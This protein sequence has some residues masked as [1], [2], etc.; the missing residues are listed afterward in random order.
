[1]H[2]SFLDHCLEHNEIPPANAYP[3]EDPD[4]ETLH[5]F[6]M[7]ESLERAAKNRRMLLKGWDIFCTEQ[8]HG[9]YDSYREIVAANGGT[10]IL[11]KG[12]MALT[13]RKRVTDVE[14]NSDDW[15]EANRAGDEGNVLY[16]ISSSSPEEMALWDKFRRLARDHDMV[17]RIVKPDWLLFV[18]M[19]QYLHWEERW[20]ASATAD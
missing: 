8:V 11:Y 3:L 17:P 7:N 13:V 14:E 20:A 4:F 10:C 19:A 2:S 9:G 18:A 6:C 16:L 5:G 1:M 15:I 12:R